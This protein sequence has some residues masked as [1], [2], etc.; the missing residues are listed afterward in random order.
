MHR[1]ARVAIRKGADENVALSNSR[2]M[3]AAILN[4]EKDHKMSGRPK[5]KQ[6]LFVAILEAFICCLVSAA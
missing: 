5:Q 3:H 6:P 4:F 2:F 1:I